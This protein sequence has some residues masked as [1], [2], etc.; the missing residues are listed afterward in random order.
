MKYGNKKTVVDGI[1]F[2]SKK[3]A[4]RYCELKLLEKCKKIEDLK[5]QQPFELLPTQKNA[6]GKVIHRKVNYIADFT[7]TEDGKFI[8]EDVKGFK[9]LVYNLKKA[10]LHHFY[11]YEIREI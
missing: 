1:T 10:M 8:V 4:R 11:G 5:L 3:E 2:D 7:Y 9:T 6:T